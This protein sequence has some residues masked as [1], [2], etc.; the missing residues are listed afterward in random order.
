MIVYPGMPNL[1]QSLLSSVGLLSRVTTRYCLRAPMEARYPPPASGNKPLVVM[2]HGYAGGVGE[3]RDLY[4]RLRLAVGDLFDFA[5]VDTLDPEMAVS[6]EAHLWRVDA[7]LDAH[8][9]TTRELYFLCYSLSGLIARRYAYLADVLPRVRALVLLATPNG[10]INW[11]NVL[12]LHWMRSHGFDAR[13]NARFPAQRHIRY[14]LLAGTAGANWVEGVPNDGVV[15]LRSV[16][17]LTEFA[18]PGAIVQA[19]QYPLNHWEL[20]R[21]PQ[22][23]ADIAAFLRVVA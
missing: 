2:L 23:A 14:Q 11:W 7:Y 6:P 12:P 1:A 19:H 10:G 13:F 16:L 15:G 9:L 5:L 22:V 20:L 18:E 3:F 8:R 4:A 17:R 21:D